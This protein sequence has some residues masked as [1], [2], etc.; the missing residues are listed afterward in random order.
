MALL[1]L[2]AHAAEGEQ[3]FAASK[4]SAA[5]AQLKARLKAA[6]RTIP[7]TDTQYFIGGYVQLDAQA[8][9]SQQVG[10][11]QETF[12]A[13][14]IPFGAAD[15]DA[16]LSVRQSQFNWVSRARTSIGEG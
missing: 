13:S 9:R 3:D 6:V 12:F 14:A 7:G 5:E 10:D 2:G 8:T 15:S 4:G 16:R 11:E 1:V